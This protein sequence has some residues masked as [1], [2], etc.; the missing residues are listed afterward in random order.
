MRHQNTRP[1][2]DMSTASEQAMLDASTVVATLTVSADGIVLA[3]NSALRKWLDLRAESDLAGRPLTEWLAGANGWAPWQAALSGG[4]S[5]AVGVQLRGRNGAVVAL[6]G[7]IA[8]VRNGNAGETRLLGVFVDTSAERQSKHALQRSARLEALASLTG[9]VAHDFNNLLTVL[10]GNLSLV[11][12]ELR[13]RPETFAK[14][15]A[16]R[17]AAKRG[18]DLIRQLLGFARSDEVEAG[19][20]DPAKIVENLQPL[21]SRALGSRISLQT[22]FA[23]DA[24]TLRANV[25]QLESVI[26]NL[27]VNARDAIES[28]GRV[29]ISLERIRLSA[30]E[31]AGRDL[32]AGSYIRLTVRDDGK[33]MPSKELERVFDPFFTTKGDRGGTGLGLSMVRSFAEQNRGTAYIESEVGRGTSVV[34]LLPHCAEHLDETSAKT[35]PLSALPTGTERV[36][37]LSS[38]EALQSTVRQ[39]LEALGYAVHSCVGGDALSTVLR[40]ARCDLLISDGPVA[41]ACADDARVE[42]ALTQCPELVRVVLSASPQ[43]PPANAQTLEAVLLKPFSLA[44]LAD[45]V[46]KTLDSRPDGRR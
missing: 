14:L 27:A 4:A 16:S 22:A 35:M 12:E 33:G 32:P 26:V 42:E 41:E 34:L 6:R 7:D 30:A 8:R 17:D 2:A 3:V 20:V 46:R 19:V 28:R 18:S 39:I 5:R 45:I 29:T 10:V 25:A 9:G 15:K 1:V 31:A 40:G 37:V 11:A 23:E 43:P 13:G 44:D 21:L 24:C 38:D 36:A